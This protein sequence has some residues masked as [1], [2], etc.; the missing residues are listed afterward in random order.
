MRRGD[1]CHAMG[2]NIEISTLNILY[3]ASI[4][5]TPLAS[6]F[7]VMIL[8]R[9]S[10][11]F[12]CLLVRKVLSLLRINVIKTLSFDFPINKCTGEFW[13]DLLCPS[14]AILNPCKKVF[15]ESAWA[16]YQ[17]RIEADCLS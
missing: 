6:A 8:I 12:F 3:L 17:A 1:P 7:P 14:L 11:C 4:K 13:K 5:S 10:H 15:S 9:I 16:R 2:D